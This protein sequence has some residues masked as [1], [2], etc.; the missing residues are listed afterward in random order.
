MGTTHRFLATITSRHTP[1]HR[2]ADNRLV[3]L[4]PFRPPIRWPDSAEA[5]GK[6]TELITGLR[7]SGVLTPVVA[8]S[9]HER[10]N[11]ALLGAGANYVC[12]KSSFANIESMLAAVRPLPFVAL[13]RASVACCSHC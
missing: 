4:T 9:S 7:L 13:P 1:N 8:V 12:S 3:R 5:N 2:C 11:S 6:G 10:G